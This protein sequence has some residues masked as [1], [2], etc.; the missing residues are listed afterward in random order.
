[1]IRDMKKKQIKDLVDKLGDKFVSLKKHKI[2]NTLAGHGSTVQFMAVGYDDSMMGKY[3]YAI[4]S[5]P[6]QALSMLYETICN[7]S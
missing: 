2:D 4:A 1:M 5:T 7:K 6:T 3:S